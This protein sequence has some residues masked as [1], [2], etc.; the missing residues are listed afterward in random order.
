MI[1]IGYMAKSVEAS[2]DWLK[3]NE[4]DDILSVSRCISKDFAD[5]INFWKHNGY[6]FFDSPEIIVS[7]AEENNI[8]LSQ[9]RWF[10]FE[11][12]EKEFDEASDEWQSFDRE[13][14]F[15]TCVVAPE[16]KK[17][18]GYDIITFSCGTSAECSP[19]SCNHF[20]EE[21]KVNRHCLFDT[22]E[23][24]MNFMDMKTYSDGEPGP[25]R[26][27]SVYEVPTPI[28]N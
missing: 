3:T 2:P 23:E 16:S 4:V 22:F 1:P 28:F 20:A 7:L 26:I 15:K 11:A 9:T 13:E 6:W 10:Y 17:L 18:M 12:Y 27:F 19:L 21:V 14:S 8:D 24:A 25:Y 5:W